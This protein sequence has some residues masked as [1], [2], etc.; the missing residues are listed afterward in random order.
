MD[1]NLSAG[2]ERKGDDSEAGFLLSVEGGE[3]ALAGERNFEPLVVKMRVVRGLSVGGEPHW[4][5]CMKREPEFG[6]WEPLEEIA[7]ETCHVP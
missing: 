5:V 7:M 6:H 1:V 3:D 4:G 2:R